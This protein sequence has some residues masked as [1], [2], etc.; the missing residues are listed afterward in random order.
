M[1]DQFEQSFRFIDNFQFVT[2]FREGEGLGSRSLTLSFIARSYWNNL[3][4]HF[5]INT[6][7][8]MLIKNINNSA[9]LLKMLVYNS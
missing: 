5:D 1:Q 9:L 4:K 8:R 6:F 3:N 7:I 2:T